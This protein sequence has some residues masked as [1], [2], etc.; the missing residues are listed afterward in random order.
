MKHTN[1][2][3]LMIA[4]FLFGAYEAEAFSFDFPERLSQVIEAFSSENEALCAYLEEEMP[5]LCGWFDPH[6]TGDPDTLEEN[7]FRRRV[8]EVYRQALLLSPARQAS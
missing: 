2:M 4:Q 5:D 8:L 6:A 3:M 7:E 1:E